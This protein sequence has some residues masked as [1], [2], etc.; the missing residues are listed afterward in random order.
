MEQDEP[1]ADVL[2]FIA[3]RIDTVPHLEALLL[4][5]ES[6]DSGIGAQELAAR[7]YV[8][9][10]ASVQILKDLEQRRLVRAGAAADEYLFD[11]R[12][13]TTGE[14]MAR[15]ATTYRRHLIRIATLIHAKASPSVREFARAFESHK[16]S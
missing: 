10:D 13:D 5:W 1:P 2:G 9:V 12:W 3:D 11:A 14:L 4:V 7:I 8:S 15:I 6:K 16:E